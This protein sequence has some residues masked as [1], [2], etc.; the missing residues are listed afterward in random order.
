[1]GPAVQQLLLFNCQRDRGCA[2]GEKLG[3]G[4]AKARAYLFQTWDGRGLVFGVLAGDGGLGDA[5][6]LGQLIL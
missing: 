4:D 2:L 1:M 6:C 3:Q 5:G